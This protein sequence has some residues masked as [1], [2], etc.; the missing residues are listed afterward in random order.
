MGKQANKKTKLKLKKSVIF[1]SFSFLSIIL[2]IIFVYK[3]IILKLLPWPYLI[4]I[5]FVFLII[6]FLFYLFLSRKKPHA[7]MLGTVMVF[8]FSLIMFIGINYQNV[9]LD[10]LHHL[11]FLNIKTENYNVITLKNSSFFKLE[12]LNQKTI[13]YVK[14]DSLEKVKNTLNEKINYYQKESANTH[15][16]ITQL[17]NK[18]VDAI[19][20]EQEEKNL[21]MEMES[22]FKDESKVI[23]T[24]K[25][26]TIYEDIKKDVELTK[27]PFNIY[28]TGIDT[29]KSISSVS[30][31]DVNIIASI[32]PN[33]HQVL[34]TSIP[35]DYYVKL[36]G[37]DDLKDKLTHAG[38][39]GVDLSITTIE[40][41]L[42]TKI[43]YYV[44]V[45][46]TS[47]IKIID[48]I[49]GIDLDNPFAFSANYQEENGDFI[50]YDFD[51]GN[52]HLNGKEALAYSRERYNL[53][54]GDIARA[55]HQQQVI[56]AVAN[57][58]LNPSIITKYPSIIG[59]LEDNFVT[60]MDLSDIT[61]FIQK[62]IKDMPSWTF[63]NQVLTGSDSS[64]YTYT[65]PNGLGYV[66]IPDEKSVDTAKEKIKSIINP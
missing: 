22:D 21:Y 59:A 55:K 14:R 65:F 53:R 15:E 28:I 3:L 5:S 19:L 8:S 13:A 29:Y 58:T 18:K 26:D 44:K 37:I 20:I 64:E 32:N 33:T 46:F 17:L 52:I 50:Y 49:D 4:I 36:H 27:E 60:N 40:D 66:M 7:R 9:T 2:S 41:L 6:N 62:Q 23:D 30:R 61:E 56:K 16:L 11:S 25:I 10:F 57:K 47:L 45:N 63:D 1:K 35:R 34:L 12:D 31:S 38:L 48:A 54:E 39:H 43:N 24:L 51:K 42:D